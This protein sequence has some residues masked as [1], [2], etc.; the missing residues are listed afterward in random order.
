[1]EM[2][3]PMPFFEALVHLGEQPIRLAHPWMEAKHEHGPVVL[4]N[5]LILGRGFVLMARM[6]DD[7]SVIPRSVTEYVQLVAA[8]FPRK[9]HLAIDP[10]EVV[11]LHSDRATRVGELEEPASGNWLDGDPDGIKVNLVNAAMPAWLKQCLA[12]GGV[13]RVVVI[14][15]PDDAEMVAGYAKDRVILKW[16]P[17]GGLDDNPILHA[18]DALDRDR[19][20]NRRLAPGPHDPLG[21]CRPHLGDLRIEDPQGALLW[22]GEK[23]REQF[24]RRRQ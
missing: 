15:R 4:I 23:E 14:G 8:V 19:P 22:I 13:T 9:L 7:V 21:Y 2:D 16:A 5:L 24:A 6:R 20:V 1:M 10:R 18:V 17:G 3:I 12:Q 11:G